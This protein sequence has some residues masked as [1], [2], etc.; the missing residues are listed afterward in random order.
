MSEELKNEEAPKKTRS[1]KVKET[2]ESEVKKPRKTKKEIVNDDELRE[3]FPANV[4]GSEEFIKA[5]KKVKPVP[6]EQTVLIMS[7]LNPSLVS[8]ITE[9]AKKQ[10]VEIVIL[11]DRVIQEYLQAK[12]EKS[13]GNKNSMSDF[14]NNASNRVHAEE[15]CVKLYTI[16]T[17]GKLGIEKSEGMIFTETEV[18]KKTNLSHSNAKKVFELLKAFGMLEYTRGNYEFK[19]HFSKSKMH[20][21]ILQEIFSVCG[22]VGNDVIRYESSINDDENLSKEEK[23]QLLRELKEYVNS[24]IF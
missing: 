24:I 9:E 7:C 2:V 19:L 14:I 1:R 12:K 18:V 23:G 5:E 22:I 21:A 10:G 16:L 15:Q 13:N 17:G 8:V 20:Q 4:E 11:E 3:Q 6:E